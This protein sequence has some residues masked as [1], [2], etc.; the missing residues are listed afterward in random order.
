MKNIWVFQLHEPL[1]EARQ[2]KVEAALSAF[3]ANWQAH[4][5][6]VPARYDI[7]ERRFILVHAQE[8]AASGCSIDRMF[9]EMLGILET[10][11]AKVAGPENVFYKNGKGEVNCFH[12][13]EAENRIKSGDIGPDTLVYN[14]SITREEEIPSFQSPLK[15]TWLAR[16]L[17]E[18]V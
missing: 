15:E 13:L 8:D 2:Q 1:Q 18:R 6:P 14:S 11:G 3:L 16:F 7:H 4:G 17:S 5:E 12:F 10:N 9:R